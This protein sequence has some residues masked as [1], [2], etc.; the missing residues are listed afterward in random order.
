MT[1]A[2]ERMIV[3]GCRPQILGIIVVGAASD[4]PA[5]LFNS[6]AY[7]AAGADGIDLTLPPSTPAVEWVAAAGQ[8]AEASG[9]TCYLRAE[10]PMAVGEHSLI[11]SSEVRARPSTR[12]VFE[13]AMAGRGSTEVI[14]PNAG[15]GR[16]MLLTLGPRLTDGELMGL[17]AAA[18]ERH[19]A[20]ISTDRVRM[21]RRVVD[22]LAAVDA[23]RGATCPSR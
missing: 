15:E 13:I 20:A 18:S 17:A 2:A 7:A 23:A 21:A 1:T 22:T 8:L 19:L 3:D 14:W 16:S 12:V 9:L 5:A 11:L 10:R 4:L 6:L